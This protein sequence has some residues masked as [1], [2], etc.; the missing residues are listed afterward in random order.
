M[1]LPQP[2][3]TQSHTFPYK[4]P[5]FLSFSEVAELFHVAGAKKPRSRARFNFLS[6]S[7]RLLRFIF[8]LQHQKSLRS[9]AEL[10]VRHIYWLGLWTFVSATFAVIPLMSNTHK[11]AQTVKTHTYTEIHTTR[12]T[13]GSCR[14]QD[15]IYY[16]R[17]LKLNV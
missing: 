11:D 5:F 13:L 1:T 10:H 2:Q 8:L 9:T 12:Q 3:H 14:K 15:G 4:L 16:R 7:F 17:A 6:V